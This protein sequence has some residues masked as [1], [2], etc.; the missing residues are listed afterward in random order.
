[1]VTVKSRRRL[2][3][4]VPEYAA[5]PKEVVAYCPSCKALQTVWFNED[6]LMLTRKFTQEGKDVYHDCGSHEPCRLYRSW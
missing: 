5:K 2:T 6:K 3:I 1:M 4:Q